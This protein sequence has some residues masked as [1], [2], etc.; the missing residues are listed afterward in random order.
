MRNRIVNTKLYG[1][2]TG[3]IWQGVVCE[4]E[5]VVSINRQSR[6]LVESVRDVC[7]DGDFQHARLA[8]SSMI[9]VTL[10]SHRGATMLRRSRQFP[11]THFPSIAQFIA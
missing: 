5:V 9:E 2:L 7:K 10:V 8:Q 11:V 4:K 1:D 6:R 3:L